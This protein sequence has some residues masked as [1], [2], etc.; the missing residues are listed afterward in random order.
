MSVIPGAIQPIV[1]TIS[2]FTHLSLQ[3]GPCM[4]SRVKIYKPSRTLKCDKGP[5]W[6]LLL[7]MLF[8]LFSS[9]LYDQC[10]STIPILRRMAQRPHVAFCAFQDPVLET[11]PNVCW[12]NML[13]FF[14][15]LFYQ[16]TALLG[17]VQVSS[18]DMFSETGQNTSKSAFTHSIRCGL[19]SA[20]SDLP[21]LPKL[22]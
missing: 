7:P 16:C 9:S 12:Q 19:F 14:L 10:Q 6:N 2:C 18:E 4:P 3:A 13:T 5:L 1:A 21:V 11:N 22:R 17:T 20:E 8:F 15:I